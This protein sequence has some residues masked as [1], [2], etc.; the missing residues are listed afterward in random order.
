MN[1]SQP[2]YRVCLEWGLGTVPSQ[3]HFSSNCVQVSHSPLNNSTICPSHDLLSS[4]DLL[5]V[6]FPFSDFYG[7]LSQPR[8]VATWK[9]NMTREIVNAPFN[10]AFPILRDSCGSDRFVDVL[11]G[12]VPTIEAFCKKLGSRKTT[13]N[14]V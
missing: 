3:M 1:A 8:V 7:R 2:L 14:R 12:D 4:P 11:L 10:N 9:K 13:T 6:Q 5:Q